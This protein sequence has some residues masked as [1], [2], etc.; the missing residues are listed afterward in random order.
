MASETENII[1]FLFKRSGKEQISHSEF[2]LTLSLDLNWFTPD[3]AKQFVEMAIK[4]KYLSKIKDT[5]KPTFD[6]N[7]IKVPVGFQPSKTVFEEKKSEERKEVLRTILERITEKTGLSE[8][9]LWEKIKSIAKDKNITNEVAAL[10][11]G[12]EYEVPLE[13][14]LDEIEEK[15]FTENKE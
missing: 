2:Y 14:F 3:T 13:D 10:L 12:K 15:L 8:K 6:V 11:V 7:Q 4:K 9:D 1:A 5:L